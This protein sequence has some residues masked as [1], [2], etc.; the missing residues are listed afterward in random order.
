MSGAEII[1]KIRISLGL[2]QGEFANKIG[3][4]KSSIC[5]YERGIR[6]PRFPIIR[7]IREL[8]KI[9]GMEFSIEDFLN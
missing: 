6:T 2:E 5:N 8:A 3:V 9:N 7:K 1:K 4:S